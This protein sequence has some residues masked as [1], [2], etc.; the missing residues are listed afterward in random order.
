MRVT[1]KIRFEAPRFR[2]ENLNARR[3]KV[4]EQISSGVRINR[5][6]DDPLGALKV[7]VLET[8]LEQTKQFERGIK[9]AYELLYSSDGVLDQGAQTLYRVKELLIQ[10]LTSVR[11]QEDLDNIAGEVEQLTEHLLT[12]SNT[13]T[14]NSYIFGGYRTN[15]PPY[16]AN[17]DF[18]GDGNAKEIELAF[19]SR[20]RVTSAGGSA[21]GDG[22]ANTVDIFDNLEQIALTIRNDDEVGRENELERLELS[23]EQVI[24]ARFEIGSLLNRVD[25]AETVNVFFQERL[26]AS[27]ADVRDTDV[28][29]AIAELSLVDTALQATLAVSSRDI[30]SSSLLDYL[31]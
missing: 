16:D 13:R 5:P 30:G 20:V 18:Q 21:F 3:S 17:R 26:P 14:G 15:Q 12:L 24:S 2:L 8:E 10:S 11:N 25:A 6:S 22:T 1:E 27:Q 31:R 4:S 9:S 28:P 19:S 7:D 29:Q 23:I